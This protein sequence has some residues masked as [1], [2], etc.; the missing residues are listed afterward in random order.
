MQAM[1]WVIEK[2]GQKGSNLL[3]LLMIANHANT[4]GTGAYPKVET[5]AKESRL[6]ERGVRYI[7]AKL[8]RSSELVIES[9]AGPYGCHR[10]SLP[11]VVRDG[12]NLRG[13]PANFAGRKQ[14]GNPPS[15]GNLSAKFA[16]G[17]GNLPAKSSNSSGKSFAPE[18]KRTETKSQNL[19]TLTRPSS[20]SS[21]GNL[22]AETSS[23]PQQRRFAMVRSLAN[24][25]S[26]ILANNP[27]CEIGDLAEELKC[28]AASNGFE[29]FDAWPGAETPIT[30]AITIAIERRKTG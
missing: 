25:A 24:A 10:Y 7:L 9:N 21:C 3:V 4:T 14:E 29:Y 20:T 26:A 1:S 2:S 5:L 23:T 13:L 11:G 28:W 18:P 12:F 30:Q 17:C 19:R 6:S 15:S 16:P 27:S 22:G 8:K